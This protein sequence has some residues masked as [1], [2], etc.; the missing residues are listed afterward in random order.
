[1]RRLGRNDRPDASPNMHFSELSRCLCNTLP[2]LGYCPCC[3]DSLVTFS[4]RQPEECHCERSE[5][6]S[7]WGLL[8][9]GTRD[10]IPRIGKSAPFLTDGLR[11]LEQ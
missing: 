10:F 6:I 9:R 2:Q 3:I 4:H 7:L 8:S 11:T 5:A 1:M